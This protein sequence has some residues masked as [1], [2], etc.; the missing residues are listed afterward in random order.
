M[1][2]CLTEWYYRSSDVFEEKERRRKSISKWTKYLY[3]SECL[4]ADFL[5]I[6]DSI[7]TK[8]WGRIMLTIKF[9]SI[10][11]KSSSG[12]LYFRR[13]YSTPSSTSMTTISCEILTRC[14]EYF[15]KIDSFR[16]TER[17]DIVTIMESKYSAWFMV[18][19]S[20]FGSYESENT[21]LK[22]VIYKNQ[23]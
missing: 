9:V 8:Y 21:V 4:E 7:N 14:I 20:E 12:I 10:V 3:I 2:P 5:Y 16:R 15:Y 18:C 11:D 22:I 23:K 17:S 19:F 6:Q 1:L 13:R